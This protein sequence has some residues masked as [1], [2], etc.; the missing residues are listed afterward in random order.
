MQASVQLDIGLMAGTKKIGTVTLNADLTVSTCMHVPVPWD[1]L[2]GPIAAVVGGGDAA[3]AG[4][5]FVQNGLV[6]GGRGLTAERRA[7]A[8]MAADVGR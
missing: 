7:M 1:S 3:G 6:V 5:V 4:C 2:P 8:W